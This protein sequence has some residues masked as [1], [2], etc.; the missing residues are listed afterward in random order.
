MRGEIRRCMRPSDPIVPCSTTSQTP[1]RRKIDK[2]KNPPFSFPKPLT[3]S[4]AFVNPPTP[5]R[6]FHSASVH[7]GPYHPGQASWASCSSWV[8]WRVWM[9]IFYMSRS[10]RT[11]FLIQVSACG[12]SIQVS[13]W[14]GVYMHAWMPPTPVRL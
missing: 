7:S 9:M 5:P 1:D 4:R 10:N 14:V 13:R 8:R 6:P 2:K 12:G 3:F 11:L